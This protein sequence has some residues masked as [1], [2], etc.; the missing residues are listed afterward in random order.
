MHWAGYCEVLEHALD[1]VDPGR[2][3]TSQPS[4][5]HVL[6]VVLWFQVLLY[7]STNAWC[8]NATQIASCSDSGTAQI[9][10]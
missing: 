2:V 8:H 3:L 9:F 7:A 10:F 1:R 4:S 5:H 6:C